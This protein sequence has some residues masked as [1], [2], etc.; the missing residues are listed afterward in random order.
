M[1]EIIV[2]AFHLNTTN[3]QLYHVYLSEVVGLKNYFIKKK[4]L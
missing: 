3:F 2:I 1:K 4:L